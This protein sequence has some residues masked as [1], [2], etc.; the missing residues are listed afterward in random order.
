MLILYVKISSVQKLQN[1]R[2]KLYYF[3]YFFNIFYQIT[4]L[5]ESIN[6]PSSLIHCPS[7]SSHKTLNITLFLRH[8]DSFVSCLQAYTASRYSIFVILSIPLTMN[9]PSSCTPSPKPASCFNQKHIEY[10]KQE[11]LK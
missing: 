6:L 9:S 8:Q 1:K 7:C 5:V 4:Y 11:P 10:R 2:H 3:L